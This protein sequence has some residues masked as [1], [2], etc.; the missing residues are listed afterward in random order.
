MAGSAKSFK[1]GPFHLDL[2]QKVLLRDG[3]LVPIAPKAALILSILVENHGR[4]VE[5]EELM[6]MVWPGVFVEEGNLSVNI[7]ALR[8][9]LSDGRPDLNVIETVPKRGYRFVM[10]VQS[11]QE[12]VGEP[13]VQAGQD[14]P[15]ADSKGLPQAVEQAPAKARG[16]FFWRLAAVFAAGCL[17]LAAWA[18]LGQTPAPRVLHVVQLTH[19]EIASAV[20]TDGARLYIGEENGGI[21]SIAQA[22]LE[23]GDVVPIPTPFRNTWLL[24]ISASRSQL[25]VASF[26]SRGDPKLAWIL[27]LTGGSPRRLGDLQ[28]ESA[29]WSPD[30][31]KIAFL[32][33]DHVLYLADSDGTNVRKLTDPGGGV[34]SW[35]PD[36]KS[37]RFTR[38]NQAKGGMSIWEIQADGA[39]LR[40][41]LP[42][43]QN[44][45]ARW[46]EGQNMG[47]WTPD[48]A[49]YLFRESFLSHDGIWAQPEKKNYWPFRRQEPTQVYAAPFAIAGFTMEASGRRIYLVSGGETEEWVRYDAGLKQFVPL[50]PALPG[51]P[52]WSPDRKWVAYID[53]D[54]CLWKARA[55]GTDRVQ[56][57]FP[58]LQ[59]FNLGWSPDGNRILMHGLDPGQ[60]GKMKIVSAE[61]GSVETLFADEL[62]GENCAFWSA[63][64]NSLLFDRTWLDKSGN[65]TRSAIMTWDMKAKHLEQLPGSEDMMCPA[66]SP[67]R[68]FIAAHS[69]DYRE[70]RLFDPRTQSWKVIARAGYFNG[71]SWTSDSKWMYYQDS[72]SGED[73]PLYRVSVPEGKVELVASRKQLLRSDVS[74]YRFHGLDPQDNPLATVIHRNADV[75]ALDLSVK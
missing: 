43:R 32:G 52:V 24:D 70:L 19:L 55:D 18:Y 61:G 45:G 63:D 62:T 1:F 59:I 39:N 46:G 48:G 33:Y 28:V 27:P 30:G 53:R 60:P 12:D 49:Y 65:A 75:Y 66:W 34:D 13:P 15:I 25:L 56:L 41:F 40:P 36:G 2:T 69:D 23:G 31:S 47:L 57:T 9:L 37:I 6:Q 72:A 29:K 44:P 74:R 5:R 26:E 51:G 73:Q 8:K 68:Q 17:G 21:S 4:L 11:D 20:L 3:N 16:V 54:H 50:Q 35:S 58:P 10:P 64:G 38:T 42:E 7:F 22:P 71:P 67:N 14:V